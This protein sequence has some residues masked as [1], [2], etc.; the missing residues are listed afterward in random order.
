MENVGAA[1]NLNVGAIM[2]TVVG[3]SQF[4]KDWAE[5]IH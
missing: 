2:A 5:Q 1:Y 4:E 3:M